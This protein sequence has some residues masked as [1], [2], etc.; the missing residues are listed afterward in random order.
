MS[1]TNGMLPTAFN[2]QPPNKTDRIHQA[3]KPLELI[4]QLIQYITKEGET[5]LDQYAGSGVVGEAALNTGRNSI[6]IEYDNEFMQNIT[7]RLSKYDGE[8]T[9]DGEEIQFEDFLDENEL[10]AY[11]H[12]QSIFDYA[13]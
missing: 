13:R 9:E 10:D 4:E 1:G 8:L 6:L 2:V 12:Q 7:V 3:E 5:V 11:N